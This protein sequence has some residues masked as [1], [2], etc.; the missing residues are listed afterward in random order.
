MNDKQH[1]VRIHIDRKPYESPNPTTGHALYKLADLGQHRELFREV[2][3]DNQ[4]DELVPN[5]D[6]A[7][8]LHQDEHL[9]S[10]RDWKIIVNGKQ[11]TVTDHT[12]TYAQVVALDPAEGAGPNALYTVSYHNGP[13]KNPE[14]EM[15]PGDKVR[16]KDGMV[17]N[18]TPTNQS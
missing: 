12:L 9:Y 7:I 1:T 11:K 3:D 4:E 8:H 6:T 2:G 15:Q 16:V 13:R 17:F 14:G 10:E 5:D 18:V